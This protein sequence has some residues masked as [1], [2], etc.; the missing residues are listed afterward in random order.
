M[1]RDAKCEWVEGRLTA[2]LDKKVIRQRACAAYSH[3]DG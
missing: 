3:A 1:T 2:Y